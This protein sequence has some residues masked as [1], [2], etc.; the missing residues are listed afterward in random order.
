MHLWLFMP[1]NCNPNGAFW[2]PA[3]CFTSIR[4]V[5]WVSECWFWLAS[6]APCALQLWQIQQTR[7]E[8][9]GCSRLFANA[10]QLEGIKKNPPVLI[11]WIYRWLMSW[12]LKLVTCTVSLSLSSPRL[13]PPSSMEQPVCWPANIAL[14]Q[15][16][17]NWE[18]TPT[19]TL[20]GDNM[21]ISINWKCAFK[22]DDLNLILCN[23]SI[24]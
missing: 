10:T 2:A 3:F 11:R 13:W 20:N 16:N 19:H 1:S 8:S 15:Q 6:E 24:K 4:H 18:H 14:Y 22:M 17:V 12:Y 21:P 5:L 9:S 7:G 23:I